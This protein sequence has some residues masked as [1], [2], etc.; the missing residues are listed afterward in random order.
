MEP[1]FWIEHLAEMEHIRHCQ[2]VHT[3]I[4]TRGMVRF[5][6][7]GVEDTTYQVETCKD[8]GAVLWSEREGKDGIPF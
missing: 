4:E 6:D 5:I 3:R 7:G 2:H 1:A 8:C